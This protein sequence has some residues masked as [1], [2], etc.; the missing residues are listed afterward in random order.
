MG[1]EDIFVNRKRKSFFDINSRTNKCKNKKRIQQLFNKIN[2][3]LLDSGES[4]IT[5]RFLDYLS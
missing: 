2:S 4:Q 1:N 5:I 3:L